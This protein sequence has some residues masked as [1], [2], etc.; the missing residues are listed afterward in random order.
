M[1]S[2]ICCSPTLFEGREV[3]VAVET[4]SPL[5]SGMTI[6]DWWGVT[7]RPPNARFMTTVD[8]DGFYD[9]LTKGCRACHSHDTS[10]GFLNTSRGSDE[11]LTR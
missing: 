6:V 5:T 9:L 3:N 4:A 10:V 2:P 8:A 1:R 7:D 11:D